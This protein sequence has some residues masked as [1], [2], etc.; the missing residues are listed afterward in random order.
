MI[1]RYAAAGVAVTLVTCTLGEQ[2]E[3]LS[4]ELRDLAA[5]RADQLG[6]YRVA[7]LQAACAA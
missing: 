6:G 3:V 1:A 5:D 2:G 7:E 4:A